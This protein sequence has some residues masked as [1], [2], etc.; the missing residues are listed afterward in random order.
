MILKAN[1]VF[2]L[3]LIAIVATSVYFGIKVFDERNADKSIV[4]ESN[5]ELYHQGN[6]TTV[7][8]DI[9]TGIHYKKSNVEGSKYE[10]R[11]NAD[12]EKITSPD[13]IK[14]NTK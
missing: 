4:D 7:F 13:R 14:K 6:D 10:L 2:L 1:Y 8:V 12:G 5:L 3:I 9:T 11:L